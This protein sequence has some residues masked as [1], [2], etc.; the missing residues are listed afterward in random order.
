MSAPLRLAAGP[1]RNGRLLASA[2]MV[3][4]LPG[5]ATR[6]QAAVN[7]VASKTVADDNGGS[8]RPSETLTYTL[9]VTDTGTTA[10]TGVGGSHPIPARTTYLPGSL[11]PSHPTHIIIQGNPPQG[12][13]RP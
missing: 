13:T 9:T 6:A 10:A 3:L 2:V 1:G 12:Q 4:L 5:L 8:P 7:L 11:P